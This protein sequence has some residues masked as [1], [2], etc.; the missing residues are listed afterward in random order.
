MSAVI[1][2]LHE[3]RAAKAQGV[4]AQVNIAARQMGFSDA[5]AVNAAVRARASYQAGK[6]AAR[7]V[8]DMQA[9][10]RDQTEGGLLA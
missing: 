3:T 7:V 5:M 8:S 1:I 2:P 10:L 9:R 4:F 6:P